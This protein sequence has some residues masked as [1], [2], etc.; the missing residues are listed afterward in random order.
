MRVQAG[1]FSLIYDPSVG[2]AEPWYIND[3][4][5]FRDHDG[6]VAPDRHHPRRAAV[7]A[8]REAPRPRDR[9]VAARP[10]DEAAVR[11]VDRS[12]ARRDAPVGAARHR[13]RRALLDVRVRR[14]R[15]RRR[16]TGSTSRPPTTARRGPATT[17]N[18]LVVDGF[19]A[20]DP[21]VLRVGD[22]WVMYYT[23]TSDAGRAATTSSPRSSPTISSTGAA[24]GSSTPTTLV[25]T[26]GGPTE[27]PFVVDRDGRYFLFIGPDWARAAWT[28]SSATAA[29][30]S[31]PTVGRACSRATIRSIRRGEPGRHHRRPRGRGRSSTR[32]VDTWVSHCGWGQGG[33]YL[34]PL[35]WSTDQT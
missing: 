23:A 13:A 34:A 19:E 20:R 21:M 6:H 25:G 11:A 18:P 30:T 12:G 10:V 29:T 15:R 28:R 27:S 3:H 32:R 9:A 35:Q 7:P 5:F 4:T 22:R 16:R 8:R 14:R 24:G 33:V 2:E 26:Y 17:T 1:T 31:R